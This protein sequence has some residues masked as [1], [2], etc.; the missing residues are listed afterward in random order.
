MPRNRFDLHVDSVNLD[1]GTIRNSDE[2]WIDG[3]LSSTPALMEIWID[4]PLSSTPA[5][6]EIWIDGPPEFY[7]SSPKVPR[8]QVCTKPRS[9][10]HRQSSSK[11]KP[12]IGPMKPPLSP[13]LSS[14]VLDQPIDEP[15]PS[16]TFDTESIVS[17]HCHLPVLPVFKDHSLLP[18]RPIQTLPR[19]KLSTSAISKLDLRSSTN[20]LNDDMERLEKTLEILLIPS[21]I[22]AQP[23][24]DQSYRSTLVIDVH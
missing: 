7:S 23:I 21:P 9:H 15:K 5:L 2:I 22:A 3:P 10:S 20:Q 6:M 8:R 14:T 17:S 24:N 11:S 1:S 13:F 12:S 4:G 19:Q 18:F 16:V